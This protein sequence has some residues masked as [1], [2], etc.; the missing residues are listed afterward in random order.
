MFAHAQMVLVLRVQQVS[1]SLAVN[2]HVAHLRENK[3]TNQTQDSELL[4]GQTVIKWILLMLACRCSGGGRRAQPHPNILASSSWFRLLIS[5]ELGKSLDFRENLQFLYK[6]RPGISSQMYRCWFN[7]PAIHE[8]RFYAL[9][10][11]PVRIK[12]DTDPFYSSRKSSFV[13]K[14]T[15]WQVCGNKSLL[16]IPWPYVHWKWAM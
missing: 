6:I 13:Q 9:Q 11:K 2:L 1:H 10:G 14:R 8:N 3:H 5:S 7:S 12:D 4:S 15:V 16:W